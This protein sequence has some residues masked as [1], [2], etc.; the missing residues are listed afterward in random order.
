[1]MPKE[2][3]TA[4]E[5]WEQFSQSPGTHPNIPDCSYAGYRYGEKTPAPPP[6]VQR[7]DVIEYGAVGDGITDDTAA[8][9][10]AIAAAGTYG[11][12]VVSFPKGAYRLSELL[13][14][15]NSGIVLSGAGTAHTQLVFHRSLTDML[16]PSRSYGKSEFSWCGGLIWAGPVDPLSMSGAVTAWK[17]RDSSWEEWK[18]GAAVAE[19][20][21]AAY[22]GDTDIVLS[23]EVDPGLQ[24][25]E[26][27]VLRWSWD[28]QDPSVLMHIAGHELMNLYPWQEEAQELLE[29]GQFLWPVEV[30]ELLPGNVVRLK[31]P[32]RIDCRANMKV[33]LH[34]PYGYLTEIGVEGLTLQMVHE[35]RTDLHLQDVGFNGVYLNQVTHGWIRDVRIRDAQNGVILS[36][37]KH[38]SVTNV[39]IEGKDHHHA[40]A[41][42]CGSH[43]NLFSGFRIDA[44][45]WHGIN[46]ERLSCGNVWANGYM[47]HGTFDSH[48]AMSFDCIRTAITVHNDGTPGGGPQSGPFLGKRVVHWN[49]L[50]SG[51]SRWVYQPDCHSNGALV[52]MQ[53]VQ[54]C[55]EPAWAMVHGDKNCIIANPGRTPTPVNLYEAQL[56]LRLQ[57]Y[58]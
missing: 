37:S 16:G 38:I 34:R 50:V 28:A 41:V 39:A 14:I 35:E 58:R 18:F 55:L 13:H 9:R 51:S 54:P 19:I 4:Q 44:K 21:T 52:G 20:K 25:G 43:D 36:S 56:S 5:L 10:R 30:A 8:I 26:L 24:P 11:G 40:F 22:T 17:Q 23:E 15:G 7:F 1:M 46:T 3:V 42:R 2:R 45:P 31:Q 12:G 33:T 57:R 6:H 29:L 49:V 53:G 27:I 47:R 32:L 48:R